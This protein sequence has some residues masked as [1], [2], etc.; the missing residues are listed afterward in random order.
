MSVMQLQKSFYRKSKDA[1]CSFI[2]LIY[3]STSALFSTFKKHMHAKQNIL[4]R[5]SIDMMNGKR[6]SG[7]QHEQSEEKEKEVI[8]KHKS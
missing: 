2:T 4:N 3:F 7:V 6:D 1:F 8:S 5:K